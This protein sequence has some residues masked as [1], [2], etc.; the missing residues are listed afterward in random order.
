[1]G[2]T[3]HHFKVGQRV[4]FRTGYPGQDLTKI[5]V[6]EKALP[7]EGAVATYRLKTETEAASRIGEE[8]ELVLVAELLG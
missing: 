6:I 2:S 8:H 3:R 4:R 5:F 1:M 7:I